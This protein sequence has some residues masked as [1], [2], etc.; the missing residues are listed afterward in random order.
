MSDSTDEI[1]AKHRF[2]V[3]CPYG[4]IAYRNGA[5]IKA[6]A[7]TCTEKRKVKRGDKTLLVPCM[8]K[9][10][11]LETKPEPSSE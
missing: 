3:I 11:P 9:V 6:S 5:D 7:F 2:L 4:H 10:E 1:L 8:H